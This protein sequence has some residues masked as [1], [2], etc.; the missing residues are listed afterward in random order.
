MVPWK[1]TVSDLEPLTS[2][3]DLRSCCNGLKIIFAGV[4]LGEASDK[5]CRI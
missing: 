5:L 4:C 3:Y 2:K 1:I